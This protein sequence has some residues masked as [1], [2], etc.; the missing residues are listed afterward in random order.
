MYGMDELAR[1]EY[2]YFRGNLPEAEFRLRRALERARERNQYEIE[3]RSLFYLLRIALHRGDCRELKE[4]LQG[5][6]AQKKQQYYRNRFVH[7]DI[8]MGWFYTQI[9]ETGRLAPW[10][11]D[12]FEEIE[13]NHRGRGL[14]ILVKAKYHLCEKKYPAALAS[15][16]G[17][18]DLEGELLF[19]KLEG[20]ALETVCRHH[21]RDSEGALA[22]LRSSYQLALASGITMPFTELGC[23]TRSLMDWALKE[24]PPDIDREWLLA[25]RRNAAGYAKRLVSVMKMFRGVEQP[26][27][28]FSPGLPRVL[29]PGPSAAAAILSH[30]EREVLFCLSRGLTRAEIAGTLSLSINTVKSVIRSIYNKLGA[31]NRSHAVQA[32]AEAG[33]LRKDN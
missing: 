33:L 25:Q 26:P 3:N 23:F 15:L 28:G 12:D 30:R 2:A 6:G 21:A 16:A 20:L 31:V 10:L 4:I 14:E 19:G 5:L 9:M 29:S 7:Y 27:A 13:I 32:A 1:G 17:R 22:A 11:K 24:G 18:R 8:A